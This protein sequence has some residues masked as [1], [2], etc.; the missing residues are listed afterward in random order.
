MEFDFNT[1]TGPTAD[2][3][4][5]NIDG[6]TDQIAV[7][8]MYNSAAGG[9]A[10]VRTIDGGQSWTN[11]SGSN[12]AGADGFP[13][14][15][16]MFNA[17]TGVSFGDP[18]G[19][20]FEMVTTSNGG[21][22]WTRVPQAN[23]PAPVNNEYG[24]VR[25]YFAL[26]GTGTIWA[27]TNNT[28]TRTLPD[29]PARML[30]STDFGRTWTIANT[31]LIGSISRIAFKDALNGIAFN[32]RLAPGAPTTPPTPGTINVIR[33][34]DGGLTWQLITPVSSPSGQFYASDIDAVSAVGSTPGFYV[35]SGGSRVPNAT[36]PTP[37]SAIGSSTSGDGITWKDIDNGVLVNATS[38]RVY[39]CMDVLSATA[40]YAGGFNDEM[41]GEGGLY[42][43]NAATPLPTRAATEYVSLHAY[44]NP[45]T[46]LFQ[47]RLEEGV[48]AVT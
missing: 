5:A 25:S 26:P 8:A 19:G 18:N 30:K 13:N 15:V 35:S 4:A 3:D 11:V 31:P 45:S 48:K 43:L 32:R 22:T 2:F 21:L 17:T 33:T 10:I 20:G 34:S 29:G 12:F 24:L 47:V 28:T 1:V 36:G 6:I 27:S 9:G 40:G 46:G 16:H 37:N 42:M 41:T 39:L 23:V 14:F 38:R 44:P 7:C